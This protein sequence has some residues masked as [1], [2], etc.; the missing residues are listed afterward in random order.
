MTF[1]FSSYV[2]VPRGWRIVRNDSELHVKQLATGRVYIVRSPLRG[3]FELYYT[4]AVQVDPAFIKRSDSLF[5]VLKSAGLLMAQPNM[6]KVIQTR[7][8][9]RRN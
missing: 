1:D 7:L 3:E 4:S 9:A 5:D 6:R 8:T 2:H